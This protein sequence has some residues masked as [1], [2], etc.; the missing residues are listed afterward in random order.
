MAKVIITGCAGFIGSNLAE[1]LLSEGHSVEGI[2]NFSYGSPEN[3]QPFA[4]HKNF[5]FLEEDLC[6]TSWMEKLNGEILVHLASQ[7]IPRYSSALR[8]LEE[9]AFMVKNS[10]KKCIQD[11]IKLVFA[12]TSD[13]YGKNT[14]YPFSE[15]HDLVMG[16]TTIKRWSYAISKM[17]TEHLIQAYA[18]EQDLKYTIMR[19]FGSYGPNQN[20]TWWGGPQAV[21]IQNLL[22]GKPLEIHGTGKQTRT[23]TFVKDTVEGIMKCIFHPESTNDIFN[24]AS[25]PNSEITIEDLAKKIIE[26]MNLSP[27]DKLKYIPYSTF[28]KYED[29]QRRVPDINKIKTQLGF[30]PQFDLD[31]GLLETIEW[32]KARYKSSKV[33]S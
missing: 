7:K 1:R 10:I 18:E 13:V 23:F 17:Y 26:L 14:Q 22:E 5:T 3:M 12:S 27:D 11:K 20:T 25:E 29:V 31:Q 16:P 19:F 9:N 28:G 33:L 2:D 6:N 21:F 4:G 24:I 32:Q 8:T 15:E 30:A